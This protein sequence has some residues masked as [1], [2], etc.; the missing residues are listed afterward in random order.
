MT[1]VLALFTGQA[2]TRETLWIG[3][4]A[5]LVYQ[6]ALERAAART[7]LPVALIA[8]L[9]GAE[10]GFQNVKNPK[11][12]AAGLGPAARRQR[13]HAGEPPRQANTRRL[14]HGGGAGTQS[15]DS[16]GPTI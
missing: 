10:S 11:S 7:G 16:T 14:D 9:I 15:P 13:D 4:P 1:L 8:E 5:A 2:E 3:R 6:P 12:T